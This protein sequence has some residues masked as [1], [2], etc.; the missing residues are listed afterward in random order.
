MAAHEALGQQFYHGTTEHLEEGAVLK[1][2]VE[3][4]RR[5]FGDARGATNEHVFMAP[6]VDSAYLWG[7]QGAGRKKNVHV[8]AVN[9]AEDIREHAPGQWAAS[10]AV[11]KQ[12]VLTSK[13]AS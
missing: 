10:S 3:L 8:Y 2:G 9:P 13:K 6:T 12:K 1:P 7:S 5:N 11:V 4:N